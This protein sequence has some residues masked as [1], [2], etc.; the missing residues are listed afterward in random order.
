MDC[1]K[2]AV[3]VERVRAG[4]GRG[5]RRLRGAESVLTARR[6]RLASI[7]N[8]I[9]DDFGKCQRESVQGVRI[10]PRERHHLRF[11]PVDISC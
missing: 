8:G 7:V 2:G 10:F 11:D 4:R 1:D 9:R 6:E 5:V 3:A